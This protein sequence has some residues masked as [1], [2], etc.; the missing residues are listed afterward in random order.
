VAYALANLP[1][2]FGSVGLLVQVPAA[3]FYAWLIMDEPFKPI[4]IIGGAVV[5]A[6]IL[7]ARAAGQSK[8]KNS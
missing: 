8:E 3:G 2:A 7:I 5:I 1:A 6:A 4:Q